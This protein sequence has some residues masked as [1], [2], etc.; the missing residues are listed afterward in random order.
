MG[1]LHKGYSAGRNIDLGRL[2]DP[3]VLTQINTIMDDIGG[4]VLTPVVACGDGA[5]GYDQARIARALRH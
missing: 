1:H 5:F 4:D 3:A 2:V